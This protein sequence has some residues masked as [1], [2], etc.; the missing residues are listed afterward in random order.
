MYISSGHAYRSTQIER[1]KW[2]EGR[3]VEVAA[4]RDLLTSKRDLLTGKRDL[5]TIKRDLLTS[6]KDL[7]TSK[8]TVEVD[9]RVA[10]HT[11]RNRHAI[12]VRRPAE[13]QEARGGETCGNR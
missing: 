7:L 12:L 4:Q 1:G 10:I 5:L 3:T 11:G 6:K 8:S 9:A 2:G 13:R